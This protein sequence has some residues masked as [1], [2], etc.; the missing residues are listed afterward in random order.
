MSG[1]DAGVTFEGGQGVM[2]AHATPTPHPG[3]QLD[4]SGHRFSWGLVS[5]VFSSGLYCKATK[6]P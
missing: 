1:K 6:P 2:R 5:R 3:L 4:F